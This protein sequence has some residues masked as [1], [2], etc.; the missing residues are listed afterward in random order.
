MGARPRTT[1]RVPGW[2]QPGG[3]TAGGRIDAG[4]GVSAGTGGDT[5]SINNFLFQPAFSHSGKDVSVFLVNKSALNP[6]DQRG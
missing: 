6:P 3:P 5:R 1:A 4:V 2:P